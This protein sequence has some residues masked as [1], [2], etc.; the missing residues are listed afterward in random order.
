MIADYLKEDHQLQQVIDENEQIVEKYHRKIEEIFQMI[1]EHSED[2]K[3]IQWSPIAAD[4]RKMEDKERTSCLEKKKLLTTIE[5]NPSS[6][7]TDS[8]QGVFL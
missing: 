1:K 8:D 3:G 6:T 2:G 5:M 4:Y 7:V